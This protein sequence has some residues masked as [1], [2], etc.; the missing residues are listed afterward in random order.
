MPWLFTVAGGQGG[1][2]RR[3]NVFVK[4]QKFCVFDKPM[5]FSFTCLFI[6]GI[7]WEETTFVGKDKWSH[8]AWTDN[9]ISTTATYQRHIPGLDQHSA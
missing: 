6:T 3:K 5:N 8:C 1:C 7:L 9:Y 4:I 2:E